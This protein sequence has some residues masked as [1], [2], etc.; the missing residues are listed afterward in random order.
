MALREAIFGLV[1]QTEAQGQDVIMAQS[2]SRPQHYRNCV[3]TLRELVMNECLQNAIIG[4]N[5]RQ[6]FF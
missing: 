5:G 2:K 3:G 4:A 6:P 1:L